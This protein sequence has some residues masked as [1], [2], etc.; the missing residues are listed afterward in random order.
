MIPFCCDALPTIVYIADSFRT[1][2]IQTENPNNGPNVTYN[3]NS[4]GSLDAGLFSCLAIDDA[5]KVA[6]EAE[7]DIA[8][9]S[10]TMITFMSVDVFVTSVEDVSNT[11]LSCSEKDEVVKNHNFKG[12]A[13][14][15]SCLT[16][17]VVFTVAAKI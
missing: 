13:E 3:K 9:L 4:F 17:D 7:R 10:E 16:I 12:V 15:L 1:N 8:K 6:T 14:L 2:T 5:F 11:E